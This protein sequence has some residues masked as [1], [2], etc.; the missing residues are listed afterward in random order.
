MKMIKVCIIG[1]GMIAKS[2]HI[3]AYQAYPRDFEI[4]AVCDF[5]EAVA[6]KTAEENH[7]G[8]YYSDA[9]EMLKTEKPDV[10]S[11]CAP[12]MLHK[13]YTMLALSY[14]ANVLCEKPLAITYQD[15]KEMFDFAKAQGKV[16]MACQSLRFLPERVRARELIQNGEAGKIYYGEVSRVRHRGIPTWGKFHLKEF[17]GGGALIDIGVHGIDS[18]IWLMNNPKPKTVSATMN[19]VHTD[20]IGD[21]KAAGA[22]KDNVTGNAFD[23]QEMN[24]E[25]FATGMIRFENDATLM[26]K[27]A[28]AANLKEENNIVLS[29]EKAGFNLEEQTVYDREDSAHSLEVAA[30]GFQDE[31]FFG[32]FCLVKNMADVLLRNGKPAVLPEETLNVTAVIE[33]AY[34]SASTGKEID[35]GE[36]FHD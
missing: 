22:L 4:T 18:A 14:G 10:V 11:V 27:V 17:S 7:I 33:A 25:S 21:P 20:E 6:K 8:H 13:E 32:H 3:P 9:E 26:F 36:Y 34:R 2:A 35:M 16:L 28:W 5:A 1:C 31:P 24:V 29:G 12:N 30:N 15:A 19:K 23:P